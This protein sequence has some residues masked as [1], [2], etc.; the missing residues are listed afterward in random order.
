MSAFSVR[1]FAALLFKSAPRTTLASLVLMG[2][3][4]LTE[5]AGLLL[6]LP[7]LAL[8]GVTGGAPTASGIWGK[9][10]PYVPHSLGGALLLYLAIVAARAALEYAESVAA[11]RVQVEVTK[12]LRERLYR[13]LVRARWETIA[14]LRGARLAH[15]LTAELERVSLTTNQLL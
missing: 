8:A 3:V 2:L 14:P 15:V 6:L 12:N 10:T 13:A 4:A 7:L 1:R 9:I 11:I 5:G